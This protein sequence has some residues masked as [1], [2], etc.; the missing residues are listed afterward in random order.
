MQSGIIKYHL[1]IY[2]PTR[3]YIYRERE[4]KEES[5]VTEGENEKQCNSFRTLQ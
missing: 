1:Y 3:K 5:C 2:I 4:F